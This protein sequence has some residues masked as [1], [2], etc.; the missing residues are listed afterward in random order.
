MTRVAAMLSLATVAVAVSACATAAAPVRA[1]WSTREAERY[2]IAA[3]LAG[4]AE[5]YLRDQGDAWAAAIV[6]RGHGD[7]AALRGIATAVRA[8][9]ARD[10]PP[11]ARDEAHPMTGKAL[12][13]MGCGEIADRAAVAAAIV[14]ATHRR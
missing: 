8:E 5:P 7:P 4:E 3:C 14:R 9:R 12:P 11:V 13:V 1:G 2:A 10:W 6:Q